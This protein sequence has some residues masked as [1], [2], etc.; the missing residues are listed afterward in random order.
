MSALVTR[1]YLLLFAG[2]LLARFVIPAHAETTE[3]DADLIKVLIIDGQNNHGHW[4]KTTMMM[5]Q[6]LEDTGKFSVDIERTKF[7]WK[8]ED[9]L[10]QF[11]LDD[12]KTYESLKKAKT[13]PDFD[14]EFSDYD[15]IVSNFGY[16]AASWP[17]ATKAKFEKYMSAGGGLVVVH[18]ADNSFGDWKEFNLMIGLGGWGGRTEKNGPYIYLDEDGNEVRDNSSGKGGNHGPQH[19]YEIVVRDPDHPIMQGLPTAWL[20][21]KD[22]LYQR[23]RG[24]GEN[25]KILATA[26]ASPKYKG[27]GNH[28]PMVMTIDYDKGRVFHTPMGHEDIAFECVGFQT[29]FLR[30]TEWAAT[31]EVTIDDV[32]ENFPSTAS[33]SRAEFE[34]KEPAAA[35]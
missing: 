26:F 20:H 32:P 22:E 10:K 8:G 2:L 31:G 4:P 30:G 21:T 24:P 29:V 15:V 17:D 12:G 14:P 1:R 9:M 18:S 35:H 23:L 33:S 27:T 28:E 11:P 19:E 16:N 34:W 3:D 13:D 25:M 5:K 6:Y 7:L